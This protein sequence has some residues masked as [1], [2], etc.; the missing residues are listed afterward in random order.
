MARN[1]GKDGGGCAG[2][3]VRN[4]YDLSPGSQTNT[5]TTVWGGSEK[6]AGR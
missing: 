1:S 2:S 4:R 6:A 5:P 3:G